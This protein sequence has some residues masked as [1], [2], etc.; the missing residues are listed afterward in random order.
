MAGLATTDLRLVEHRLVEGTVSLS[1]VFAPVIR[2]CELIAVTQ[3]VIL[4]AGLSPIG[5]RGPGGLP[6]A[7]G[8][9]AHAVH[10]R[11]RLVQQVQLGEPIEHDPMQLLPQPGLLPLA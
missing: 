2:A 7:L 11:P 4:A 1:W 10:R 5:R 8:P 3:H 6:A 9:H